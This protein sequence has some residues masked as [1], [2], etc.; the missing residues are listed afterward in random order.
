M[1]R[2]TTC[3]TWHDTQTQWNIQIATGNS[4]EI[5]LPR[6]SKTCQ[7]LGRRL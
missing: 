2:I 6:N 3:P 1:V 5:L 7:E 4:Q